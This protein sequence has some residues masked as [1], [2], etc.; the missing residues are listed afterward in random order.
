VV[1]GETNEIAGRLLAANGR[2]LRK[3]FVHFIA[4]EKAEATGAWLS[5]QQSGEVPAGVGLP[6]SSS[7][8]LLLFRQISNKSPTDSKPGSV[9]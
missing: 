4:A 7:L 8:V 5:D 9:G 6:A 1:G 3:P 2:N